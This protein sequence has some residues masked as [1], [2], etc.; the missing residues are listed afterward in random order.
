MKKIEALIN[1]D[2][3]Q[4]KNEALRKAIESLVADYKNDP[5]PEGFVKDAKENIEKIHA[6]VK[7]YA[8]NALKPEGNTDKSVEH[9]E[10]ALQEAMRIESQYVHEEEDAYEEGDMHGILENVVTG[11]NQA[12]SDNSAGRRVKVAIDTANLFLNWEADI[13]KNQQ[14]RFGMIVQFDIPFRQEMERAMK[15]LLTQ[16]RT[17]G[18]VGEKE[19]DRLGRPV[20]QVR[21]ILDELTDLSIDLED[22]D[23]TI[24]AAARLGLEDAL[25]L[26]DPDAVLDAVASETDD[27]GEFLSDISDSKLR[28]Q[29][30]EIHKR[31][32]DVVKAA[33]PAVPSKKTTSKAKAKKAQKRPR[34]GS[35][36]AR[37]LA[38]EVADE[39]DNV[40]RWEIDD[41]IPIILFRSHLR[42]AASCANDA[43]F[44][45]NLA[46]CTHAMRGDIR[47]VRDS[48]VQEDLLDQIS[49]L[50]KHID[51]HQS[52]QSE[53][54]RLHFRSEAKRRILV[55]EIIL[56]YLND[57]HFDL[58]NLDDRT[59]LEDWDTADAPIVKAL[60]N[61]LKQALALLED[62]KY[63]TRIQRFA[64]TLQSKLD[65]MKSKSLAAK[66][67]LLKLDFDWIVAK[68]QRDQNRA[69]KT[70]NL[71][72]HV[73]LAV[74][75]LREA[76]IGISDGGDR[77]NIAQWRMDLAFVMDEDDPKK[78]VSAAMAEIKR[79]E[80]RK[81]GI[82][83]YLTH[84]RVGEIYE[85]LERNIEHWNKSGAGKRKDGGSKGVYALDKL[86]ELRESLGKLRMDPD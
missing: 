55:R 64:E 70:A 34:P 53:V 72:D 58:T 50:Q 57:V 79:T 16:L 84:K 26:E 18:Y 74:D 41:V 21:E 31:L 44:W 35:T 27:F 52:Q 83:D 15:T 46:E 5:D 67:W 25:E 30:W 77:I 76:G 8:P 3:A 68:A 10:N 80:D 17:P 20:H 49:N 12:L 85:R 62:E 75:E 1:I 7:Q 13:E 86:A 29:L 78:L 60:Y 32:V 39:Y 23:D 47:F 28:E 71:N 40:E 2:L 19:I 48:V 63:T 82:S 36:K 33:R 69:N 42:H 4:I 54:E 73:Q 22:E 43:E 38:L 59:D 56:D 81:K 37:E 61:E 51:D 11:L 24:V 14:L 9:I 66:L 45:E 6:L 65:K